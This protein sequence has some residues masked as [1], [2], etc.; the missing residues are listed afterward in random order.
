MISNQPFCEK[1]NAQIFALSRVKKLAL[2]FIFPES[3]KRGYKKIIRRGQV[4]FGVAD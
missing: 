4:I 2:I 1:I 3:L